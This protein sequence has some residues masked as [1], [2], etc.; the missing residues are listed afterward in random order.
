MS[1]IINVGATAND[2]TGDPLRNAFIKVNQNFADIDAILQ[3]VLTTSSVIPIS[4]VS[5]LQTILTNLQNNVNSLNSDVTDIN[6]AISAINDALNDQ[7]IS[8]TDLYSQLTALQ[9]LVNTKIGEAPIDGLTYG[10]KDGA[11]VEVSGGSTGSFVPYTGA[12]ADV[13]LGTYSITAGGGLFVIPFPGNVNNYFRI[14]TPYGDPNFKQIAFQNFGDGIS[15]SEDQYVSINANIEEGIN[16]AIGNGDNSATYAFG[17]GGHFL[18]SGDGVIYNNFSIVPEEIYTDKKVASD[19]GLYVKNFPGNAFNTFN[20]GGFYGNNPNF[21]QIQFYNFGDDID[22]SSDKS[23]EINA[24]IEEGFSA[25]VRDVDGQLGTI[26]VNYS[27]VNI[28][29]NNDTDSNLIQVFP[30]Y[31]DF[32]RKV[33]TQEAFERADDVYGSFSVAK[34]NAEYLNLSFVSKGDIE[35]VSDLNFSLNAEEGIS[36]I[37]TSQDA[38]QTSNLTHNISGLNFLLVEGTDTSSI[39]AQITGTTFNQPISV[40]KITMNSTAQTAGE[41]Q[42][43]WNDADGT[44]D[45]GLKGGNVTLQVGQ[46]SVIRVVNKTATNITLQESAY[47]AVRVTGAQ[48]NR[49]KVD[50]AQATTDVLSAETI[51]IVTE[52]IP[53][54]QEGFITTNGLVRNINTTGSLQGETWLDGDILY[55]SPTVAG[56]LTKIKPTAPNHLVIIG[57]VV[58]AHATQGQIF[59][60]V[61]NGYELDELHN[62]AISAGVTGGQALIYN[63][64]NQV[65]ENR[66]ITEYND[67]EIRRGGYVMYDDFHTSNSS[68]QSPFVRNALSVGTFA[69]FSSANHP[70]ITRISSSANVNSGGNILCFNSGAP[71][72]AVFGAAGMKWDAILRLPAS[73]VATTT[74]R[75]GMLH[76]SNTN[77]DM[78]NGNY[79]EIT[80]STLVGKTANGST[81]TTT[82]SFALTGNVFYHLRTIY[83]STT[84]NTFEVYDMNGTLLFT[85]TSTTNINTGSA[86]CQ[87]GIIATDSA[88]G[89]RNLVEIDYMGFTYPGFNRGSLT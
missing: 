22:F 77:A 15:F 72:T 38:T 47:Q 68:G 3:D 65:W 2:H 17:L 37:L 34:A 57:Y 32:S 33:Y 39:N 69:T 78:Q 59:V 75:C 8:I 56:Q 26:A 20:L 16:F 60:K 87:P 54:N 61:D 42:M 80:G 43:V 83:N 1:Q 18:G 84:L 12:T 58:R 66:N 81:R 53:N 6:T 23:I 73:P 10:R 11:W 44:L 55:L 24:N 85:A 21:R 41:A 51:G 40:P 79:F 82:S 63:N 46:E 36:S 89:T 50:L 48:G 86:T 25:N 14:G 35:G 4:Q 13:D 45:I 88:G 5:G 52:T 62:V 70:G 27:G 9:T 29:V 67:L 76:G 19:G 74:I 49:L 28:Q 31:T 30:N 7:N 64:T 71:V